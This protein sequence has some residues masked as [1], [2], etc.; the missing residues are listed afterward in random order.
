M[1]DDLGISGALREVQD[2]TEQLQ[3]DTTQLLADTAN[4]LAALPAAGRAV[5]DAVWDAAKAGRIDASIASRAAASNPVLSPPMAAGVE[6]PLVLGILSLT[7]GLK[8]ESAVSIAD[9]DV[10]HDLISITGSGYLLRAFIQRLATTAT[11]WSIELIVDGNTSSG[12]ISTSNSCTQVLHGNLTPTDSSS[13]SY[14]IDPCF[15]LVFK[16]SLKVRVKRTSGASSAG[17]NLYHQ[18]VRTG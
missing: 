16:T 17:A 10:W 7:T 15:P 2:D 8:A 11:T 13:V 14:R 1:I 9:T 12:A 5:S 4:A 3:L 18:I 6:F